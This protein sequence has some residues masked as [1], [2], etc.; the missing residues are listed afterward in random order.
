MG[1]QADRTGGSLWVLVGLAISLSLIGYS[2]DIDQSTLET[3]LTASRSLGWLGIVCLGIGYCLVATL[4]VPLMPMTA[5]VGYALGFWTGFWCL[6]PA[7]IVSAVLSHWIGARFLVNRLE[8]ILT[9]FPKARILC[10]AAAQTGWKSV[11]ANRLLP[12]CPFAIQN[13]LLGAVGVRKRD[14]AIGTAIGII[15]ASVFALYCG[16]VAQELTIAFTQPEAGL[17]MGRVLLLCL[18]ALVLLIV[19][20][21]GRIVLKQAA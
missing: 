6:W 9:R 13:M 17:P 11:A 16:S 18:A 5:V 20:V 19:L 12:V 14:Q 2:T 8:P 10:E 3:V 4:P 21:W 1:E 7:A 15:P